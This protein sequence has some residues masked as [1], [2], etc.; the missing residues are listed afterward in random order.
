MLH[1]AVVRYDADV[2]LRARDRLGESPVWDGRSG[3]LHRVDAVAGLVRSPHLV[4]G[5]ERTYDVGRHCP[6]PG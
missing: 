4:T 5:R 3:V 2:L 6:S 1:P